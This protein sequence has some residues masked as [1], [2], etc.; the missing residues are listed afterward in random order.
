LVKLLLASPAQSFLASGLVETFDQD[1]FSHLD[2]YMFE[3]WGI[4]FDKERG[5]SF[6]GGAMFVAL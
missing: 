4:L 3:K 5:Q 2:M 6:S 1:F